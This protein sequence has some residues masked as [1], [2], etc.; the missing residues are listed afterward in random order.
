MDATLHLRCTLNKI[1]HN[2]RTCIYKAVLGCA[3]LGLSVLQLF[4]A[5]LWMDV[6]RYIVP[7]QYQFVC[8]HTHTLQVMYS[9]AHGCISWAQGMLQCGLCYWVRIR[10]SQATV[11]A[12]HT[13]SDSCSR[14]TFTVPMHMHTS[15]DTSA[16]CLPGV[17]PQRPY[18]C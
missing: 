14:C 10:G 16:W 9:T 1:I 15:P 8:T 2:I 11:G 6:R 13:I 4:T 17:K 5:A 18:C 3:G 7:H 12:S